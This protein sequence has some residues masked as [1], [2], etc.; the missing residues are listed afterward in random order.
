MMRS[1]AVG[2]FLAR[3]GDPACILYCISDIVLSRGCARLSGDHGETVGVPLEELK[4]RYGPVARLTFLDNRPAGEG[5]MVTVSIDRLKES[6]RLSI[7]LRRSSGEPYLVVSDNQSDVRLNTFQA[8]IN[9]SGKHAGI[10]GLLVTNGILEDRLLPNGA[11]ELT[12]I[13]RLVMISHEMRNAERIP[14][15]PE[16]IPA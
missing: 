7:A 3:K 5:G 6:Q 4:E 8:V 9:D 10:K 15:A 13:A 2:D 14:P 11:H 16:R 12:A 1:Y